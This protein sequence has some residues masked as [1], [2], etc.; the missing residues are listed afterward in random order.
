MAGSHE[1]KRFIFNFKFL[2]HQ[3]LLRNVYTSETIDERAGNN[4]NI[5]TIKYAIMKKTLA[6]AKYEQVGSPTGSTQ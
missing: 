4:L 1:R 6:V 5:Y 3:A 2:A